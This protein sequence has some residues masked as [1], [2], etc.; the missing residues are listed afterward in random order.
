YWYGVPD[1]LEALGHTVCVGQVDPFNDSTD[2]GRQLLAQAIECAADSGHAK[3]NI[4]GH[5]QGGLDARVVAH[6]APELVAS[7]T[8][9]ATPHYGTPIADVVLGF[10]PNAG[11]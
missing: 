8:T 11:A 4:I 3:V 10:T 9:V 1:H 5:S 6:L 2:R 7:V